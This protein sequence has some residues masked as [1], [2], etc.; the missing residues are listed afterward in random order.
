MR[1][2]ER[3][4]DTLRKKLSFKYKLTLLNE[5]TLDDVFSMRVSRLTALLAGLLLAGVMLAIFVGLILATPLGQL[6]PGYLDKELRTEAIESR[7][8]IDSLAEQAMR[9]E[10]YFNNI[11]TILMGDAVSDTLAPLDSIQIVSIDSLPGKSQREQEFARRFEEEEKFNLTI[12]STRPPGDGM[13]FYAPV[14]GIVTRAFDPLEQ[15]A[16]ELLCAKN[17]LVSSPLDGVVVF[18]EYTLADGYVMVIQHDDGFLSIF[19]NLAAPM[20]EPGQEV[21]AGNMIGMMPRETKREA[22][23]TLRFELRQ[24]G[25]ALDPQKY[26]SF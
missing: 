26:I 23:L 14:K 16:T 22:D 25:E 5:A 6:L 10:V 21:H 18:V 24:H 20:R 9:R 7:L 4:I 19:R 2:N 15:N 17:A 12:L 11:R 1:P 8:R 3:K 13:V